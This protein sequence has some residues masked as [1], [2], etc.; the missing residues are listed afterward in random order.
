M[1]H[2]TNQCAAISQA[3]GQPQPLTALWEYLRRRRLAGATPAE[4][5]GE[6]ERAR[7]ACAQ[8]GRHRDEDLILEGMDFLVGWC[9]PRLR[10][11][12]AMDGLPQ[13]S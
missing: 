6:L 2:D 1:N 8:A 5:L 9:S 11:D 7:A 13:Q 10:L 4:L 12:A 3:L